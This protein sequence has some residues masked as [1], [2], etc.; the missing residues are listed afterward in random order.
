MKCKRCQGRAEVQL[1][2]HNAAFCRPCFLF[3]FERQVERTI[4]KDRMLAAGQSVLV[5]VSGGKDSLALWHVLTAQGYPTTGLHL[6]LGI[7]QY[8]AGSRAK[9]EAFAAARGL[10]L[11]VKELRDLEEDVS[12]PAVT[13]FTNRRPC[14]ACGVVKRHLFD[15]VALEHGVDV[16]ATGHNLDDEAARLL[17]NVLHWQREYL[18][19]QQPVLRP[20]HAKF[21][22]KIRPFY[23]VSELE[24]AVYA[25][26]RGIDYVVDECPNSVGATQ[27]TY[28]ALLNR[29]EDEMPGT[30]RTFVREFQR[31]VQPAFAAVAQSPPTECSECGMPAFGATCSYCSLLGEVRSKRA[32]TRATA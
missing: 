2:A 4:R 9:T 19:K 11:V 28:K 23:L 17:G 5:A 22:T 18:A 6:S 20:T 3:F 16:L 1:R 32:R 15:T 7:G 29:L 12:I 25:F 24:T 8:S 30:K 13:A 31:T 27:L 26:F 14:A 21:V 10:P